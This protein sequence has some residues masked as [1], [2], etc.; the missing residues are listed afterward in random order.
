MAVSLLSRL[1]YQVTGSSGRVSQRDYLIGLGAHEV[2]DRSE[3]NGKVRPLAKERW[4]GAIDVA[5]GNTLANV[6]SQIHYGGAVAAC[7]LAESMELP[8]SVAPFILRG[9]TLYGIDSVMASIEKRQQA[10]DRLAKDLDL[11]QLEKMIVEIPF[12]DLPAA[13]EAILQGNVRG[14]SVVKIPD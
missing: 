3:F 6:L 5:G 14:R 8:A 1:G 9:V 7:G 10:W 12:E 11:D 2:I 13:A 4:A